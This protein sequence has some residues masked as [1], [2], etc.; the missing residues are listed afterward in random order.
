MSVQAKSATK[1]KIG[2]G[3]PS[4]WI[5]KWTWPSLKSIA[6]EQ[7]TWLWKCL[8]FTHMDCSLPQ[9]K[10]EDILRSVMLMKSLTDL[11]VSIT[12]GTHEMF[13]WAPFGPVKVE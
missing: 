13:R 6:V 10:N 1:E 12:F 9:I 8:Y 7:I 3:L 2:F 4:I 11:F 5:S